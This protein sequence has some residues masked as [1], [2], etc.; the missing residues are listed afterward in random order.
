MKRLEILKDRIT[1]ESIANIEILSSSK[2]DQL[3]NDPVNARTS[4][5]IKMYRSQISVVEIR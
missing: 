2:Y 4:R 3:N 5:P 1:L